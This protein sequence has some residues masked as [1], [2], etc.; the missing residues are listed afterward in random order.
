MNGIIGCHWK[1]SDLLLEWKKYLVLVHLLISAT[2]DCLFDA[3]SA[4]VIKQKKKNLHGSRP[5][6]KEQCLRFIM[7][8]FKFWTHF[9]IIQQGMTSKF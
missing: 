7:M 1:N 4:F 6:F 2:A 3:N 8:I 9:G 5:F